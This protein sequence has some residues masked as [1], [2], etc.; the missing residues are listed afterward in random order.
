[1]CCVAEGADDGGAAAG[2][3]G[4]EKAKNKNKIEAAAATTTKTKSPKE[5]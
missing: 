5:I 2:E 4:V 1:M 3:G